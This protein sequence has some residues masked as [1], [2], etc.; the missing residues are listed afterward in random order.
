VQAA[1]AAAMD[2]S[3]IPNYQWPTYGP[4]TTN[5]HAL[6]AGGPTEPSNRDRG[7]A[8]LVTQRPK[9]LIWD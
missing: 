9:R 6:H 4:Q 1:L 8:S 3:P 7:S 2:G 5:G